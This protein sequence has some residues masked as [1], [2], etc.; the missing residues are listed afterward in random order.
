[1]CRC[2]APNCVGYLGRKPGEKSAKEIAVGLQAKKAADAARAAA[3]GRRGFKK[4]LKNPF[5][6]LGGGGKRGVK[7]SSAMERAKR[8]IANGSKR[9]PVVPKRNGVDV[10]KWAQDNAV[11]APGVSMDPPPTAGP[12]TSTSISTAPPQ[13][14]LQTLAH[15]REPTSPEKRDSPS[16]RKSGWAKWLRKI[17][18][19]KHRTIEEWHEERIKRRRGIAWMNM[20]IAEFGVAPS[21]SDAPLTPQAY[22]DGRPPAGSVNSFANTLAARGMGSKG[23]KDLGGRSNL[24]RD[25]KREFGDGAW[26]TPS[27]SRTASMSPTKRAPA[28]EGP[29]EDEDPL[30]RSAQ[31]GKSAEEWGGGREPSK[32][33]SIAA[34]NGAPMGWAFVTEDTTKASREPVIDLDLPRSARRARTSL[35]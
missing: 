3:R 8:A 34:R 12:S 25:R 21:P 23:V 15:D 10:R 29:G 32:Q 14:P 9:A 16:S 17:A 26:V 33:R 24:V 13:T 5:R 35:Q 28:G 22:S 18:A 27:G 20:M 2:G 30:E 11:E 1:M 6:R 31:R 4:P 19:E 7:F